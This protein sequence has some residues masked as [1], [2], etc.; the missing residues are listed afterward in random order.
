MR[1]PCRAQHRLRAR[2]AGGRARGVCT[3]SW[4]NALHFGTANNVVAV[5]AHAELYEVFVDLIAKLDLPTIG[6]TT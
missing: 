6:P 2:E 1:Q 3:D 5:R 4:P